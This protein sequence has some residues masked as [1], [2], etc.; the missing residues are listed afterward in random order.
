MLAE[1]LPE[2]WKQELRAAL[3]SPSFHE[4]ERFVE[5]E[6]REAT[7]FPSEEDLFSAFRLTPYEDVRVLLLGQDP[8][9]GPGQAHGLAFSVKPGVAPPPSLVNMFKE[10]ESDV[11][12]PRPKDGSL[13]PWA[14]QGVLLLNAVLTVRQAKPNSHAGH[15]WEDFT[16]AVIRAVS[17]KDDPVVFLLWGRYAQKK[18]KLIDSKRHVVIEGTHPSPL[19]ASNGFFGSRPFSAVNAALESHGRPPIDWRLSA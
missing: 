11:G 10:L 5:A 15:G 6:R 14:R 3:A 13:I 1:G 8:Y 17:A 16:D 19:S 7:V 12:V 2:D 4:L 9:H 18:K